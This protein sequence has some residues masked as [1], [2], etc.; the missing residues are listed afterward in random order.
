MVAFPRRLLVAL[1]LLLGCAALF[2]A[3]P[4]TAYACSGTEPFDFNQA[5]L[6]AEGVIERVT[7]RPDLRPPATPGARGG[8]GS[9]FTPVEV[10][11][12]VERTIK[13]TAT[14]DRVTFIEPR[15]VMILPD[16]RVVYAGASGA[17]G[18]LDADPAGKYALIVFTTD[19]E[20]RLTVHRL[21][22]AAFGDGPA[23]PRIVRFRDYI[24]ARLTLP[25][26]PNTG[27]GGADAVVPGSEWNAGAA[28]AGVVVMAGVLLAV[29][30]RYGKRAIV[31][32]SPRAAGGG[33]GR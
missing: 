29:R 24:L 22:G 31:P 3:A 7:F 19:R 26:L 10:S 27:A 18:I 28:L 25:G 1:G 17:C 9:P 14:G 8:E 30:R 33:G 20:G 32:R 2:A 23:D 13:G 4:R 5:T 21:Q 12:R 6:I 16:G 11:L 15:S